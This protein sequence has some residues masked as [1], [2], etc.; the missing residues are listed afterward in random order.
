M[1]PSGQ[2]GINLASLTNRLERLIF[3]HRLSVIM[4][5]V[6]LTAL[7]ALSATRLQIDA[8]YTKQLP[9]QHEY[10]KTFMDYQEE[11]GGANRVLI[12][13]MV[14]E[15]DI[16]TPEF[17]NTLRAATDEAFFLPSVARSRVRSLFTPNVRFA[18]V[19]AGGFAG[20]NVVPAEFTPTPEGLAKVRENILKAGLVGRLV[21]SDF[22]GAIISAELL[23][24][25]PITGQKVDYVQVSQLLEEKIRDR[26]QD[27]S[28]TVHIIGFAKVVGDIT[29]GAIRV[30]QF[31]AIAFVITALLVYLYSMS[32]SLTLVLL[33]C[34]LIAVIWQLGML[35][36]LGFGIDPMSILVPFLVFAIGVSH[37]VQMISALMADFQKGSACA[38]AARCSFR[39][40][41]LPGTVA[42]VSDTIGFSAILLIDIGI[43]QEMAI[44]AS[45]GVAAIIL[46]NLILLPVLISYLKLRNDL[47]RRYRRRA[48]TAVPYWRRLATVTN[49]RTAALVI[50]LALG[51]L[52]IGLWKGTDV[53]IG[54]LHRGAPELRPDSRYNLDSAVITERFSIGVDVISVFVETTSSGCIDYEIMSLIERFNW[55][56]TN[57]PGVHAVVSTASIAK[58]INAGWNEGSLKWRILPRNRHSL[59]QATDSIKTNS[60]LVNADCSVMPVLVFTTDHKAETIA[61][62]VTAVKAFQEQF[63]TPEVRFRLAGSNVGV[64]AAA[65]EA[66]AAAQFPMLFYIFSAIIVLCLLLYRSLAAT[67]S[68]VLPL[69]LVSLLAYALM[70]TLEIGL[71]VNTL[72]VVALGVGIGV[73]YGIYIYSRFQE[74]LQNG[75]HIHQAYLQTL[76]V[77]GIGVLLTAMTLAFGVATWIFSPLQFQADM[78]LLL[79]FMFLVNMLGALLLLPAL[80]RW[81]L[82]VR[83]R[84]H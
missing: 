10:M 2:N 71:K 70:S 16:F 12:A 24:I 39:R 20:G 43:I 56:I 67:L 38:Q 23:E 77:T 41:L 17:F 68:I 54:D 80:A 8:G 6:L 59:V 21:A 82:P 28:V 22:S 84:M 45:L 1:N 55:N 42:L 63:G 65:N 9:L 36:L 40:L 64:M 66:V 57:V 60:G 74:Q 7:M 37:G 58:V 73:D 27:D 32:W 26:F 30:I 69:G 75:A 50:V 51:L 15:G 47:R 53:K 49:R 25:D 76:S 81:L 13:L 14:R 83:R 61:R 33:G 62:I 5:F 4:L 31:F 34:S 19:V 18:E 52:A 48:A 3:G 78:G 29:D 79:M 46:T 11:F 72:P 44:T 35:P